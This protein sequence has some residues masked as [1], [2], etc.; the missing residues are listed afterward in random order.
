[1]ANKMQNMA[2][3]CEEKL[4]LAKNTLQSVGQSSRIQ[5][6]EP[7]RSCFF[8]QTLNSAVCVGAGHV[9]VGERGASAL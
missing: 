2:V 9:S 1:M 5:T 3:D 7:A 4:T 6:A 8:I